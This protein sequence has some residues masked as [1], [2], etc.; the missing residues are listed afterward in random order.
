MTVASHILVVDDNATNRKLLATLLVFEGYRISEAADGAE[1]LAIAQHDRPALVISDILMP[2]MDGYEFVR[3]LRADPATAGIHVIFHTA[4]YHERE[5]RSLADQCGV[6]RVIVKPCPAPVLV[7]AVADVLAGEPASTPPVTGPDEGFDTEHLRL[8]T[9]KLSASADA[10]RA[11]NSRLAALTE[12]NLQMASEHD[13]RQLLQSVCTHARA[14]LGARFAVLAV[15]DKLLPRGLITCSSGLALPVPTDIADPREDAGVLGRA[16]RERSARRLFSQD[17]APLQLGLPPQFPAVRSALVVPVCS[18]TRNHGWLCLG[19]KVGA[20]AFDAEDERLLAILGAQLGRIYENGSLYREV[21]EQ[22]TQL[23][24]EMEERARAAEQLRASEE[25]FRELAENIQDV[26]FVAD[27]GMRQTAYVSP[28]Y[29]R[30]WGRP[31]ATVLNREGGWMETVHPD[32]QARVG[33]E[34]A[35]VLANFPAEGRFEFR[36]IRP[37]GAVRWVITRIFPVL[38]RQGTVL[39]TV[40][41][42]RDITDRKLAELRVIRLNRTHRVLSG[43][44]SL[45]VR[46][47]ERN[48]LLRD[49]CRLAVEDGGF[50]GAWCGLLEPGSAEL[51]PLVVAGVAE[52]LPA[53]VCIRIEPDNIPHSVVAEAM[54]A[55]EPRLCNDLAL[56]GAPVIYRAQYLQRGCRSMVALPL[57]VAGAAAGCFVLLADVAGYFDAEEMRLLV[58][59]ADD[60]SFALDHIGKAERLDFLASFEPLTGLANR[61]EF[62]RRVEQYVDVASHTQSRFAVVV[63][64]PENFEALNNALGRAA[65]DEVLRQAAARFALAAGG[66]D[67]VGHLGSDQFAAIVSG[68]MEAAGFSRLIDELWRKWLGEPFA[69][70]DREL[71]LSARAGVALYPADGTTADALLT[72]ASAALRN[73]KQSGRPVG[74]YTRHLGEKIAERLELERDLRRALE[75]GEYQ[76]HYQP[77]V[78]LVHRRVQGVEALLRWG[79]PGHGL[80]P[81][82]AFVPLLEETGLIVEVGA[83]ALRQASL[84]RNRWAEL[85]LAAPRTAVNVSA[86]QLR[87]EDFVAVVGAAVRAAH[88][89][90]GLDIEVTESVLMTD[91]TDNLQKLAAVRDF[92]VGIALDD[93]GTGYSSLSY[94]AKLPVSV[95]KID[96]S[97]VASMIDDPSVVT[98]VST[99]ISLARSLKLESV[100]EGVET[101]EQAKILRLLGCDQMQGYLISRPLPFD[102]M[103]A[104]LASRSS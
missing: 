48:G 58:E 22:A 68:S 86:V 57:V 79:R 70:G 25:R 51:R 26:F 101:E 76:L 92:G 84:D 17:G 42:T 88:D 11:T 64:D 12:A 52:D 45:I 16:C 81:P 60:I 97:F 99:V 14:L 21:Q 100:A 93:F 27:P 54:L 13:P 56:D 8:L 90:D 69:I 96:R 35:K 33:T 31:V 78:D 5:A 4:N 10:L 59:L 67:I 104:F 82:G 102:G 24:V 72:N 71:E 32:D 15:N 62:Q 66:R 36:I 38:D 65:G 18:L 73:A 40:G 63:A 29:E 37:D 41:V 94:L 77:K 23:L 1:G 89:K 30:V 75:H 83:W 19:E 95:L 9:N 50:R 98:L 47:T 80:V 53:T 34:V 20:A 3:R 85:G 103:T 39:R 44:N 91:V 61:R 55:G 28:G 46:A 7:Q 2:S 43:I 74:F 6:A 87:R 49:S